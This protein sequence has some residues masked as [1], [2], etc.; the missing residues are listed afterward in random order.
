MGEAVRNASV[1]SARTACP[2]AV[3]SALTRT[4]QGDVAGSPF[5]GHKNP[6]PP[7]AKYHAGLSRAGD[8]HSA[9]ACPLGC[10]L[11]RGGFWVLCKSSDLQPPRSLPAPV[12]PPP[13]LLPFSLWHVGWTVGE[14]RPSLLLTFYAPRL[15]FF[16]GTA[17]SGHRSQKMFTVLCFLRS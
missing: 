16:R 5:T 2:A 17:F 13:A 6:P 11:G 12:L 9:Q 8:Q 1:S 10:C 3:P 14:G 7:F 4:P 15:L